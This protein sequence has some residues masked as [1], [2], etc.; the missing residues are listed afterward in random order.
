MDLFVE[1][2]QINEERERIAKEERKK[3]QQNISI[4]SFSKKSRARAKTAMAARNARRG[5][6]L[7]RLEQELDSQSYKRMISRF[8]EVFNNNLK[9]F[10]EKLTSNGDERF[11]SYCSNLCTRLDYNGFI[12]GS[13]KLD[14]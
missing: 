6:H 13:L 9:D 1:M 14:A 7:E 12:S 5:E 8:N 2:T 11:Q 3:R 10:M 4:N